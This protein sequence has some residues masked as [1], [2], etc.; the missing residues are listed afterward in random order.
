MVVSK[1]EA[2]R[3]VAP[4]CSAGGLWRHLPLHVGIILVSQR[5]GRAQR[6]QD[7]AEGRRGELYQVAGSSGVHAELKRTVA[8]PTAPRLLVYLVTAGGESRP[9]RREER[10]AGPRTRERSNPG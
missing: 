4:P 7:Q 3:L 6:G 1:G 2:A 8:A 10:L 5:R 9:V